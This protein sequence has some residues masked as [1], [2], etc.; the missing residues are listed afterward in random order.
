MTLT[1]GVTLF[2]SS[3]TGLYIYLPIP[4]YQNVNEAQLAA[5][6]GLVAGLAA[7]F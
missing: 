5:R 2:N 7:T 6:M 4:I 3:G 1:P